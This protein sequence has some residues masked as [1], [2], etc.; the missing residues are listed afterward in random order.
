MQNSEISSIIETGEKLLNLKFTPKAKDKIIKYSCGLPSICHQLC[1]N[2][3]FNMGITETQLR[4]VLIDNQD[5]DEAI[6][7][8][9]DEKSDTLKSEYDKA[10]KVS[11]NVTINL[12]K[13]ILNASININKDEFSF[14][15][16][17]SKIKKNTRRDEVE[18]SLI[19]LCSIKRSE[20][21]VFDDNSNK[22]RLNNLFLKGYVMLQMAGDK[23]YLQVAGIKNLTMV[24][25]LLEIIEKDLMDDDYEID[26]EE[27]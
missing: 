25:R 8:Y 2:I 18:K 11:N 26:I 7:K 6:E 24:D 21:L 9:V 12:F 14:D 17:Y 13:E 23:A 15:E 16:I 19:D 22:Y 3:C 27:L 10:V 4:Q 5:L 20:I 1:L